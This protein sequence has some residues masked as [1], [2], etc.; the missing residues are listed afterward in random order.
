MLVGVVL[1]GLGQ[2]RMGFVSR[3]ISAGV[4]VGFMFGLGLTIIV[5]Q[6]PKLLGIPAGDGDV[7]AQA[8]HL[9]AHLGDTNPWTAAVGLGSLALLLGLKRVAPA[10]PAALGVVVAGIVAVALFDLAGRG[11]EVLG[12]ID[13]A[14]PMPA[15]P[16][17]G[18]DELVG[19]LPGAAAVAIIG[20]AES[21]TVAESMA[22]EHRYTV[23]PDR[24]LRAV[25][26][27]NVLSGLFQGFITG[28]GASQSAPTTGPGPRP[29]WCRCWCPGSPWSPPSPCCRCSGTCPRRPLGRW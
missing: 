3:F 4:Q 21:A 15:I 29:S 7:F 6:L 20:Y 19:L 8:G 26:I 18:W 1:I 25:G 28:G 27:A 13:G 14:V 22:N 10:A 16:S 9:A 23:E 12:A 17:L 5:G 11:V 2:L 24:E